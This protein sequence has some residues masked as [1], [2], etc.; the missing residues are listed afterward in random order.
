[1]SWTADRPGNWLF[2]CHLQYH[3]LGHLPISSMLAGKATISRAKF[4]DDFARHAGMGGLTMLVTVAGSPR[5]IASADPPA[6]TIHLIAEKGADSQP[7]APVYRYVLQDNSGST[8]PPGDIGPPI[9]LERGTP[10][11]I[12]VKNELDEPTSVHWHGMELADSYYDGVPGLSG[13]GNHRAPMIMPGATFQAR[14]TPPRSGTFIYHAHMDD[15]WQLRGGL[16]GPLIVVDPGK[17]YDPSTD[18]IVMLTSPHLIKDGDKKVFING[19]FA[20][21]AFVFRAGVPQ[22]IRLVNVTTN[23]ARAFVSLASG[24]RIL[25]WD[26]V[27]VDGADVDPSRRAPETAAHIITIG[28]TRDFSFTPTKRGDL[29]LQVWG[30]PKTMKVQT[31]V[32]HVI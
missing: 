9:V 32:I 26:P 14:F 2:H 23:R 27:A 12:D 25:Q 11:A 29:R 1:M 15:V 31:I 6:R 21:P 3:V 5:A 17:R 24:A 7:N 13:E 19:S 16:A 4:N 10:V 28:Q 8:A 30:D 22:R 20:P 18:H